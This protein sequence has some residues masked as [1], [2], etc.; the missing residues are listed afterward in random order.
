M[1]LSRPASWEDWGWYQWF[2][3]LEGLPT[4]LSHLPASLVR[5]RCLPWFPRHSVPLPQRK[6]LPH[7]EL[8]CVDFM[9][10]EMGCVFLLKG[11]HR[12]RRLYKMFPQTKESVGKWTHASVLVNPLDAS[13]V[14]V[15][16]KLTACLVKV[17][18]VTHEETWG[19]DSGIRYTWTEAWEG[20]LKGRQRDRNYRVGLICSSPLSQPYK[21][22]RRRD[23]PQQSHLASRLTQLLA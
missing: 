6:K 20:F 18:H 16:G 10:L 15:W 14:G 22:I 23:P 12:E 7:A 21:G 1:L 4:H 3:L 9:M 2:W 11:K 17:L 5:Y 19:W 8:Q 13:H